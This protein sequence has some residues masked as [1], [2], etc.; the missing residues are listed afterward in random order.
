[1]EERS[2]VEAAGFQVAVSCNL[3]PRLVPH[4]LAAFGLLVH[5]HLES[6]SQIPKQSYLACRT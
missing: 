1:M 4:P 5:L 3:G 2:E 6:H